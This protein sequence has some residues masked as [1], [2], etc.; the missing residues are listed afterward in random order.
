MPRISDVLD[1]VEKRGRLVV[2]SA[3]L[4]ERLPGVSRSALQQALQRQQRLG[5]VIRAGRRTDQWVIVP[6]MHAATG[7]P[8][9]E[10]W[11]H[12]YLASGL[13]V[14]YYVGL[15]SAAEAYG[16]S[17]YATTVT[18]IIVAE[19]RRPLKLGRHELRF[20]KRQ[21]ITEVPTQWHETPDGRY[22][23]ST[24]ELTMLDLIR[25]HSLVGGFIRVSEVVGQLATHATDAGTSHALDA[26]H[27][28][29]TAQ[30]LGVLL[31]MASSPLSNTVASWLSHFPLRPVRLDPQFAG[32]LIA[33]DVFRVLRPEHLEGANA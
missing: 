28:V 32:A 6:L 4:A 1:D 18:Q 17:P 5:R 21:R 11:L 3:Q 30:R 8:P 2:T 33:D 14:P 7:A 10:V 25:R 29:P 19:Q 22:L 24:P 12:P 16:V 26:V 20:H 13:K 27:D 23:V 15:L 31:S 9:L